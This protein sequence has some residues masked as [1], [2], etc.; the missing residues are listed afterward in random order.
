M[1]K[2]NFTEISFPYIMLV[3]V[4]E[5]KWRNGYF[6][7]NNML[8]LVFLG[9]FQFDR[10]RHNLKRSWHNIFLWLHGHR[11]DGVSFAKFDQVC[12][13]NPWR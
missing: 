1:I 6:L 12:R 11:G 3:Y 8:A 13:S 2:W 7:S 9:C 5:D 10:S 4:G